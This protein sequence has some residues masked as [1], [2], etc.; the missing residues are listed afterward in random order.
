M[1]F[2]S[3]CD[4]QIIFQIL[5]YFVLYQLDIVKPSSKIS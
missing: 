5:W 2:Y 1:N 4:L 3:R